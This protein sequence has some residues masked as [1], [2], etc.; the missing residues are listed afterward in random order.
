MLDIDSHIFTGMQTDFSPSKHPAQFLKDAKNIRITSSDKENFMSISAEKSDVHIVFNTDSLRFPIAQCV[1]LGSCCVANYLV[2][3]CQTKQTPNSLYF[4]DRIIVVNL[5]TGVAEDLYYNPSNQ[6]LGFDIA[7]PI[8]AIGSYENDL[9]VKVYWTDNKNQPRM[10]N[11]IHEAYTWEHDFDFTPPL[12]LEENITINRISNNTGSFPAGVIQYVFTYYKQYGQET[13]I[14][15]ASPLHYITHED[16]GGK[17]GD[18]IPVAFNINIDNIDPHFDFVRIYSIIRTSLDAEPSCKR[19]AD[20]KTGHSVLNISFLDTNREGETITPSDLLYL[21]KPVFTANT[22]EIKDNVMFFGN[23]ALQ[24]KSLMNINGFKPALLHTT[25]DLSTEIKTVD[26]KPVINGK[27]KYGMVFDESLSGFKNREYYRLGIQAQYENGSWSEPAYIGDFQVNSPNMNAPSNNGEELKKLVIKYRLE[28]EL[29]LLLQKNGYKRVRPVIVAPDK[30]NRTILCQGVV[31]PTMYTEK[32]RFTDKRIYGQSS[33]FFRPKIKSLLQDAVVETVSAQRNSEFFTPTINTP[34]SGT[35]DTL[36]YNNNWMWW[37]PSAIKL[38]EIQGMYND[39]NKFKVDWRLLTLHS[40]DIAEDDS[41]KSSYYIGAKCSGVGFVSFEHTDSE[42]SIKTSS[43]VLSTLANGAMNP[44]K[45]GNY[46]LGLISGIYYEDAVADDY[47]GKI[48]PYSDIISPVKWMV[49]PWQ[50]EGS[51]NNDV[52]RSGRSSVLEKKILANMRY[53]NTEWI[54]PFPVGIKNGSSIEVFN[55]DNLDISRLD[56]DINYMGNI[57]TLLKPD[58]H[59]GKYFASFYGSDGLNPTPENSN[60]LFKTWSYFANRPYGQGLYAYSNSLW[61]KLGKYSGDIGDTNQYLV[62]DR[63]TVRMKYKSSPH[64]VFATAMTDI[65]SNTLS[66]T[67]FCCLLPIVEMYKDFDPDTA[68]GG[69]S[70]EALMN[71]QWI[72]A[73]EPVTINTDEQFT[74]IL[75]EYGDTYYSRYDYVKTYPFTNEDANQVVEIGSF[76]LETHL[77]VDGRYDRNRGQLHADFFSMQNF[78]LI[79]KVYSQRNNFFTYRILSEDN[80]KS[81]RYPNMITWSLPKTPGADVDAYTMTTLASSYYVDSKDPYIYALRLWNE[82]LLCFMRYGVYKV[83]YNSRVQIQ[84]SD[85]VPIEIANSNKLEGVIEVYSEAGCANKF[86][87]TT[88]PVGLYF[89]DSINGH[90]YKFD[91]KFSDLSIQLNSTLLSKKWGHELSRL[92]DW[93]CRLLYNPVQFEL[94]INYGEEYVCYSEHIGQFISRCD[95]CRY[96][97]LYQNKDKVLGVELIY[98]SLVPEQKRIGINEIHS[99]SYLPFDITFVSNKE[100]VRDK[101]FSNIEFR[102]DLFENGETK[103]NIQPFN[104]VRCWNEYQDTL[105]ID[106]NNIKDKP[107]NIKEKFRIWRIDVPRNAANKRDRIRNTWCYINLVSDFADEVSIHDV[108]VYCYF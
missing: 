44:R 47:D 13:S 85:N 103:H 25:D 24:N 100:M 54:E 81:K 55:N 51:L 53:A 37:N 15:Y 42:L 104:K 48:Q 60:V 78:N 32:E 52:P 92:A 94:Y 34:F 41:E 89:I 80:Y 66:R 108:N 62:V 28:K 29:G 71:N 79:N 61:N 14:F 4:E 96:V 93:N 91:G 86:A 84:T 12:A 56:T 101:I 102:G 3:F 98:N 88:S 2:L 105:L 7:Y 18:I 83:L 10:L 16:R 90:L 99:G 23:I 77:N 97:S 69:T 95:T 75:Y 45:N 43:P 70:E 82:N 106:L 5:N 36:P 27:Y 1:V 31:N 50:A 17:T 11:V 58:G 57:D 40:P 22:I 39:E 46:S 49:Y 30:S 87:I 19:V 6:Y 68:Y 72:P 65:G 67:N 21:N 20:I 59:D 33:W 8:E 26:L 74:D 35:F 9:V 73:G 64:V 63:N 38:T 107:S 76:T